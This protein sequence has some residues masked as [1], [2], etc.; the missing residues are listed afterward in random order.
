MRLRRCK[1]VYKTTVSVMEKPGARLKWQAADSKKVLAHLVVRVYVV[2]SKLSQRA[3][4]SVQW[5]C[6]LMK[7]R[8]R[9]ASVYRPICARAEMSGAGEIWINP[10]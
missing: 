7:T 5:M 2:H 3:A 4:T 6:P 10:P 8:R 9:V 1:T